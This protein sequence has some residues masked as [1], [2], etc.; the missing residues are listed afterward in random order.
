MS[1]EREVRQVGESRV[2]VAVA[3]PLRRRLMDILRVDGPATASM[4]SERTGEAVGNISH[5]LKVLG[6]SQ[7]IEEAPELARD[8]RERWWRLVSDGLRWSTSQFAGDPAGEVIASAAESMNLDHHMGMVR[9]W[10]ASGRG[11]SGPWSEAAFST[12]H[13]L[14]LSPD[15]LRE[16]SREL[17]A[18]LDRWANRPVP[19]DGVAREPV[20][21]FA[22]GVPGQP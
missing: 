8:R 9:S 4:L 22:H 14:R 7:L 2:L 16:L 13:W 18:L 11:L 12:D 20:Y 5:H 17:I 6:A 21:V 10:L 15:E 19:D 3:H 1:D